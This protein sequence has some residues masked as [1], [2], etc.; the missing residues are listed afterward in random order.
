MNDPLHYDLLIA[1]I[2][3]V[4]VSCMLGGSN[5]LVTVYWYFGVYIY[6][7]ASM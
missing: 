1:T 5:Q 7:N 2:N 4:H 3:T 6:H